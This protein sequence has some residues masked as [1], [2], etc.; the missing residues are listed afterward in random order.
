MHWAAKYI[1]LKY[2]PAARGPKTV[3]CW[4]LIYL[5]YREQFKTQLPEHPGICEHDT[6]QAARLIERGIELD[7]IRIANPFDGVLVA[8]SERT[9]I[10]HIGLYINGDGGYVMHCRPSLNV[11]CQRIRDIRR[12]GMKRIEFYRYRLWPSS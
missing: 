8:M 9:A 7:W 2:E 4:G 6:V 1:E 11:A 12:S 3:D 5:V 10:H